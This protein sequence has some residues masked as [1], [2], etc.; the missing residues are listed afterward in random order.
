MM[1]ETALK[2][3]Q[4]V[5]MAMT[6]AFNDESH[7][8]HDELPRELRQMQNHPELRKLK[9]EI[10]DLKKTIKIN[11]EIMS[12]VMQENM[13]K[14][15]QLKDVTKQCK[16]D[17]VIIASLTSD[18]VQLEDKWLILD[19]IKA[20][21]E[22][23]AEDADRY[24]LEQ[25]EDYKDQLDRKEYIIQM[26]EYKWNDIERIMANYAK[27]DYVLKDQLVQLKYL[28]DET[29]SGRGISSV[30]KENESYKKQ[31]KMA[32]QEVDN[33]VSVIQDL[34]QSHNESSLEEIM[35]EMSYTSGGTGSY[36][37]DNFPPSVPVL[38]LQP[39]TM[40]TKDNTNYKQLWED[41]SNYI[42]EVENYNRD[43]D[44]KNKKLFDYIK[45]RTVKYKL[46][47]KDSFNR[48]Q[49]VKKKLQEYDGLNQ[50]VLETL[51]IHEKFME[52][53]SY[54]D[55]DGRSSAFSHGSDLN[56]IAIGGVN[57]MEEWP[58]FRI[59]GKLIVANGSSSHHRRAKSKPYFF[60]QK[61]DARKVSIQKLENDLAEINRRSPSMSLAKMKSTPQGA[62]N[63]HNNLI[64]NR[65]RFPR[66]KASPSDIS[67]IEFSERRCESPIGGDEIFGSSFDSKE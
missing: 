28:C 52:M 23:A 47:A 31:L 48:I 22:Q 65:N 64:E 51:N 18:I 4:K 54:S 37:L 34:Q 19:Q 35:E 25:I 17:K 63:Y 32:S 5:G 40:M 6:Q 2:K 20:F 7:Y 24:W 62:H 13:T 43:L 61:S 15:K 66:L 57:M 9:F 3:K 44:Q 55:C 67:G 58:S 38:N 50:S 29:S 27:T 14:C 30:I 36:K 42:Q 56:P 46:N 16:E 59:D 49:V 45:T 11:K 12:F 8:Y 21:H 1:A 33:L 60:K 26:K 39:V 41:Q 10:K 53:R